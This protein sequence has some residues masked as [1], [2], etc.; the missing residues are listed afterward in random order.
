MISIEEFSP[1]YLQQ[2]I[3]LILPIQQIEFEVPITLEDQQDLLMIPS[4]YQNG[5][6]NFWIA[7]DNE[8]VI[9]TIALKNFNEHQAALRKMFVE[10]NFRGKIFGTAQRLLD[11]LL[12][13]SKQKAL[14]EIYLGTLSQMLAA[15]AFYRRN[16]FIEIRKEELPPDFP[17]VHFDSLFFK[18]KVV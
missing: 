3:D 11:T 9:G 17:L 6:G 10:K 18:L 2:V 8:K 14:E 7:V 5:K 12:G 4:F 15:H 13:W 1:E 16:R